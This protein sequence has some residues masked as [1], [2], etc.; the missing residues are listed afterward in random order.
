MKTGIRAVG[1]LAIIVLAGCAGDL[2][3]R[4]VGATLAANGR[5]LDPYTERGIDDAEAAG[6][7]DA[8]NAKLARE[9][10]AANQELVAEMVGGGAQ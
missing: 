3:V 5:I 1:L 6:D 8:L 2:Q 9:L 7:V 4:G 10:L